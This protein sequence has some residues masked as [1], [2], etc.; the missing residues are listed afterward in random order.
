MAITP[1]R[2]LSIATRWPDLWE[3]TDLSN[4]FGQP[5]S[6]LDVYETEDEVVVKANVAGV[7][8]EDIDLTF[9]EGVLWIKARKSEEV[10]EQDKTHYQK[11][12]W[13]YSYKVVVPGKIDLQKEPEANLD[14]GVLTVEFHK[15][16][17][18]K[19]KKLEVKNK[20]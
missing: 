16:E 18:S 14:N 7:Q 20:K 2:P 4:W 6:N 3:E 9:E 19:P 5:T 17:A 10:G 15:A 13:S 12:S 11:S 8:A 1:W